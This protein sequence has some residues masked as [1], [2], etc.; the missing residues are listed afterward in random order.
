MLTC[1]CMQITMHRMVNQSTQF[2]QN[3]INEDVSK[4]HIW[5]HSRGNSARLMQETKPRC[6]LIQFSVGSNSNF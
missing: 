1:V 5:E 4:V 3:T 2:N 6:L